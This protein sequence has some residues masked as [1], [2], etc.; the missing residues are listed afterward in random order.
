MEASKLTA[1]TCIEI[2][3]NYIP[4]CS[5]LSAAPLATDA[6]VVRFLFFWYPIVLPPS[7]LRNAGL[8]IRTLYYNGWDGSE[9]CLPLVPTQHEGPQIDG[10][11]QRILV[12]RFCD[13]FYFY[14]FP[15]E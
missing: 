1:L 4:H 10:V 11:L 5:S 15:S 8:H 14:F 13:F 6:G 2:W 9:L 7:S 12:E 3:S